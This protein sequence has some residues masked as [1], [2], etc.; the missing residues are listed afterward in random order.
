MQV[1]GVWH[2]VDAHSADWM[3]FTFTC[4]TPSSNS[5]MGVVTADAWS[6][7]VDPFGYGQRPVE[8]WLAI[9]RADGVPKQHMEL[10]IHGTPLPAS[11]MYPTIGYEYPD[12]TLT[13][14][15]YLSR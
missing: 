14:F 7:G 12:H 3:Y 8:Q 5:T 9:A 11:L 2:A 13:D 1:Q 4:A 10:P 15:K 6:P